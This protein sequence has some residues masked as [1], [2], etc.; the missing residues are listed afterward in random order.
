MK[1]K[2]ER[3][4]P[5]VID[6]MDVDKSY[7]FL[8]ILRKIATK[9][10]LYPIRVKLDMDTIVYDLKDDRFRAVSENDRNY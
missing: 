4:L 3:L 7:N 5:Y 2:I 1:S 10:N 6:F 8:N 9:Y